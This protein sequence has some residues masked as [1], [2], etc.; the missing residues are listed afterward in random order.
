MYPPGRRVQ[1]SLAYYCIVLEHY[2]AVA[3]LLDVKLYSSAFALARPLYEALVKGIW[4]HRCANETD[5]E[6]YASGKEFEQVGPLTEELLQ[7]E[8]SSVVSRQVR[9]VKQKYWKI[10]SSLTHVGHQQVRRWLS[11]NG[12]E[13]KYQEGEIKELANFVGFMAVSAGI[14][15]AR[16]EAATLE[17]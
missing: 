14:E 15:M 1:L 7:L 4:L 10:L 8:P 2:Q 12:V 9:S 16:L 5:L 6:Q 17:R 3:H 13:P 11:P